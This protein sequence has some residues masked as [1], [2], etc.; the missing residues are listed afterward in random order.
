MQLGQRSC[1]GLIVRI[2]GNEMASGGG[3]VMQNSFGIATGIARAYD[4][5][6]LL[7]H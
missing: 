6:L 5:I 7:V 2:G 3:P 1:K 4:R